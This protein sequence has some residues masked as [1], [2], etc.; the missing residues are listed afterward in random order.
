MPARGLRVAD[1]SAWNRPSQEGKHSCLPTVMV[2]A[3][4]RAEVPPRGRVPA[5]GLRDVDRGPVDDGT[6]LVNEHGAHSPLTPINQ[7]PVMEC[8]T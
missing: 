4:L 6:S 8:G 7:M 3:Y 1:T 5:R 2:Q